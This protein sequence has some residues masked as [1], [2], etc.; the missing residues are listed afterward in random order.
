MIF[1]VVDSLDEIKKVKQP[2]ESRIGPKNEPI[3]QSI[4]F[5]G[6]REDP[7][8]IGSFFTTTTKK[9][10]PELNTLLHG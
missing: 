9:S 6:T 4:P 7:L 8:P 5:A 2:S 3:E 10:N 1:D